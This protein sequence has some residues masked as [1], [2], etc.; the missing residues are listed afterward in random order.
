MAISHEVEA[1]PP[2]DAGIRQPRAWWQL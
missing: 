1:N 2:R